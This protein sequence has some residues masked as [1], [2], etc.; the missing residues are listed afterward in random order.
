MVVVISKEMNDLVL[1][2]MEKQ[3]QLIRD[4]KRPLSIIFDEMNGLQHYVRCG[5]ICSECLGS[6]DEAK[7]LLAHLMDKGITT[8]AELLKDKW[9]NRYRLRYEEKGERLFSIAKDTD[10][11][12]LECDCGFARVRSL[13][14][15]R[16]YWI[17]DSCLHTRE[18]GVH[19]E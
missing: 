13:G 15:P 4:R 11:R 16:E 5:T 7:A 17:F 14:H 18:V 3:A 19:N 8:K 9:Y 6:L 1:A 10:V 12:V 2:K